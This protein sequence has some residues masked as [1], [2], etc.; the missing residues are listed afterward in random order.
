MKTQKKYLTITTREVWRIEILDSTKL[1]AAVEAHA[2]RCK[3]PITQDGYLSGLVKRVILSGFSANN[4][5]ETG[6]LVRLEKTD[7]KMRFGK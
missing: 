4:P 1:A 7:E 3:L 2:K 6:V 5:D